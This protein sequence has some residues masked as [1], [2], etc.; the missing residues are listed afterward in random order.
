MNTELPETQYTVVA[1][2]VGGRRNKIF[3]SGDTVTA[4]DFPTGN[5]PHLVQ[6]GFLK[7]KKEE[8]IELPPFSNAAG[9][10][11]RKLRIAFVT[12]IWKRDN[13]FEIFAE[14]IKLLKKEFKEVEIQCFV[15]GS[16]GAKSEKLVKKHKFEYVEIANTPL[17]IKFNMAALVARK[18]N[19]DFCMMLGSDDL[20]SP[21]LFSRYLINAQK[22]VDYSYITD[23]FFYDTISGKASYWGG[24]TKP[25]NKGHAAG[26]GRMLSARLMQAMSWQ[27]W[28]NDR[29]HDLLD[30]SMD[31]K[32]KR[33]LHTREEIRA[34]DSGCALD[35]KSSVN[36]TPFK[37][38]DNTTYV[39]IDPATLLEKHFSKKI[40]TL[41]CAV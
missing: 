6:K 31:M 25:F 27:P 40:A 5:I 26:I 7:E 17:G 3:R 8:M 36:M 29:L 32:L 30:T 15:A 39:D 9:G 1:S 23:C 18:W 14:G 34:A 35:I 13:I 16:E 28:L 10:K 4:K 41:I 21:D 19:P 12:G 11:K 37:L 2:A 20:I 38:W 22:N 33:I 24:Y